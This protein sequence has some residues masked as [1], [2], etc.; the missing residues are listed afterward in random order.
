MSAQYYVD[1]TT[2]S[3][4]TAV[5]MDSGLTVCAPTGYYS[6]GIISRYLN[7]TSSGCFLDAPADCPSCA[8]PCGGTINASGGTGLYR[9]TLDVGGTASDVGAIIVSMDPSSVPDG[10]KVDF[11]TQS[12]NIGVRERSAISV[13]G[14]T[15]NSVGYAAGSAGNFTFIGVDGGCGIDEIPGTYDLDVFNYINGGFQNSGTTE[16]VTITNADLVL[17]KKE[18][19]TSITPGNIVVVV[20][21]PNTSPNII[22]ISIIGPCD[23]TA[24]S[25][26][27]SCPVLLDAFSSQ[28]VP[29]STSTEAC[30]LPENDSLY[31]VSTALRASTMNPDVRDQVF[32]DPYGNVRATDGWRTYTTSNN[33]RFKYETNLGVVTQVVPCS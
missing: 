21:K 8:E 18:F 28:L 31:C 25:G 19:G 3:N 26:A 1:G 32:Q 5:Y 16:S 22:T 2:L 29:L 6:D 4:S 24:W 9:V 17:N 27:A 11:G 20:P 14:G 13:G 12:Y 30:S 15:S 10:I 23:G 33:N 7:V